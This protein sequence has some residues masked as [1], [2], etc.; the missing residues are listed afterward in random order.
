MAVEGGGGAKLLEPI[1]EFSNVAGYEANVQKQLYRFGNKKSKNEEN[2]VIHN[3]IQ[4]NKN[5]QA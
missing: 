4:V 2:N 5:T 3:N 1:D